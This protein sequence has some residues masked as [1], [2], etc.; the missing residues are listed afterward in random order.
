[1]IAA[2]RLRGGALALAVV[3]GAAL[4]AGAAAPLAYRE[5]LPGGTVLLVA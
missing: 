5:V 3:C 1:M 2:S 4:A